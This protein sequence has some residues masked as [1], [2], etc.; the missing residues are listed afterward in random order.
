MSDGTT[1]HDYPPESV[2]IAYLLEQHGW[3]S[4][5]VRVG[6]SEVEIG[7][8][9]YCTDA[10]GDLVRAA[11]AIATGAM[12]AQVIF[13][14][15]PTLWGIVIQDGWQSALRPQSY[16]FSVRSRSRDDGTSPSQVSSWSPKAT[17]RR[18]PSRWRYRKRLTWCLRSMARRVIL[19]DGTCIRSWLVHWSPWMP[20][21]LRRHNR[22]LGVRFRLDPCLR[23][24][25]VIGALTAANCASPCRDS[26]FRR[27]GILRR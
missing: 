24:T 17:S 2:T 13:D 21:L 20:L 1:F 18:M 23:Q 16:R 4:L 25:T 19:P 5:N 22:A 12:T 7:S 15:E 8:V 6:G 10:L 9:G 27:A 11:V 3:A 14:G 26:R